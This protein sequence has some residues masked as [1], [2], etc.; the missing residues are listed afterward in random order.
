[1]K[2]PGQVG[3]NILHHVASLQQ[4]AMNPSE[5]TL[6]DSNGTDADNDIEVHLGKKQSVIHRGAAGSQGWG[7]GLK[8]VKPGAPYI[9]KSV[10]MRCISIHLESVQRKESAA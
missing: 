8:S 6:S 2:I 3:H 5:S 9:T 1:M 4:D 7:V 10:G